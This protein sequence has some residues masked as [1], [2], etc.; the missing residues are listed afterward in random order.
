MET[1]SSPEQLHDY[2]RVTSPRLW[3][4]LGAIVVLLVGF[5]AYA[6]TATMENVLQISGELESY[7][8]IDDE[9]GETTR[10]T[11]LTCE[12]TDEDREVIKTGM[13]ARLGAETGMVTYIFEDHDEATGENN[14]NAIVVMDNPKLTLPEGKYDVEV[15]LESTTPISFLW[16]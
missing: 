13:K 14:R 10:H 8:I 1:I 15:V 2:M 6:S 4:L 3:M 12:L 5:I 11:F 7:E 16:N 9:K